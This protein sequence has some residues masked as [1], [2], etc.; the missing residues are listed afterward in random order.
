MSVRKVPGAGYICLPHPPASDT[1]QHQ[2][3]YRCSS[4]SRAFNKYQCK[5]ANVAGVRTIRTDIQ[6]VKT[7]NSKGSAKQEDKSSRPAW[8]RQ[9]AHRSVHKKGSCNS[10]MDC[11]PSSSIQFRFSTL[12]LPSFWAPK[13][14]FRGLHSADDE[15]MKHGVRKEVRLFSKEFY[16][17]SI[18]RLMQRCKSVLLMKDTLWENNLYFV[19]NVPMVCVN[20]IIVVAMISKKEIGDFTF[21]PPL[22]YSSY[23]IILCTPPL[24]GA[25]VESGLELLFH[26]PSVPA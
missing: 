21:V 6:V 8:Q 2:P 24:S 14:T 26:L 12:L 19:K 20:F 18:Q 9:A 16:V 10:G 13:D 11:S 3:D 4:Q 22:V 15:E 23:Y 1:V 5:M 25:E 17:T 7:T